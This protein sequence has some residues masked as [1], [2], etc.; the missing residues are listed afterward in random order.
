[1]GASRP[2]GAGLL[3]FL[4]DV[5]AHGAQAAL[6]ALNLD[7][8]AGRPVDEIFLALADFVCPNTGTIDAGIA[9]EA[10]VETIVELSE[11]GFADLNGLTV[12]QMQTVF[13]IYATHAIEA[14]LCNDIGGSLIT[15]PASVLAA[16]GVEKQ[17][18]DLI[19]R[20]VADALTAARGALQTLTHENVHGFVEGVYEGAFEALQGLGQAEDDQP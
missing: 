2:T 4:S 6:H 11:Q 13:E 5:Q 17:L 14:R 12:D 20:G 10:F 3:S 15:V 8:L 9:R 19:R 18:R 7:A 1:M 16:A